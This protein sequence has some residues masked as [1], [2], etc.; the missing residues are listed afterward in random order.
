MNKKKRFNAVRKLQ[1]PDCMPVWPRAR[2]QLIYGMGWLLTDI[3]GNQWYDSDKCAQAVLWS[4]KHINYDVA[5]PAYTD[6]AFGVPSV[7]GS[8]AIP[9]KYGTCVEITNDKPVKRKADWYLIQ[10]KWPD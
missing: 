8:I 1:Q 5:I 2:S 9:H 3:T 4:L 6:S 10:K 7:G